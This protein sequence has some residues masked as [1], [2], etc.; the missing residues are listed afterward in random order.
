M[1]YPHLR[2]T[3]WPFPTVPQPE[4]CDFIADRTRL[5]EDISGLLRTLSRQDSSSIHLV[6]SWFGAGKTHTLYYLSNQ[7]N[8]RPSAERR[9]HATYSEFPK[10]A[11]SF[12]DLY[13]AFAAGLNFDDLVDA[14]LEISTSPTAAT[15]ERT[16]L[17]A[18]ADLV[19]ALKVLAMGTPVDQT[20]ALRW[21]RGDS[22]PAS[23]YRR[24]GIAQ[25]IR[26]S[27]EASK[28]LA[29]IIKLFSLAADSSGRGM[30]RVLWLLDEFQRIESLPPRIRRE[31]STGLHSTFNSAP[32]GL[33]IMLSFSGHPS[34]Q[35]PEWLTP[36][37]RDRIGRTKVLMLP[38]MVTEEGLEFV[39]DLLE[40]FRMFH[41]HTDS[42]PY[43][44]FTKDSCVT[45]LNDIQSGEDLKP[46]SIMLAFGAVLQE[47]EPL[48]EQGQITD[49][50]SEFAARVL[51]EYVRASGGED[52]I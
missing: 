27:D 3:K 26:T 11:Q 37:L 1:D 24:V 20:I 42:N 40:R 16:M 31:I 48:L 44:P 23:D 32:S 46:R 15:F 33:S 43:F 41:L 25:R 30:S 18:S 13:R 2:L 45:I 47:A 28:I 51:R 50:S 19:N 38:P 39:R 7:A 36:E 29:A 21:L 6:W 4:F 9:L 17:L 34:E 12:L 52:D 8:A 22:L 35:L 5:Q 49:I 14:F 10:A